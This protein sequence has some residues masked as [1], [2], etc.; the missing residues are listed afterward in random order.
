MSV[1][2]AATRTTPRWGLMAL[3]VL[4]ASALVF[5]VGFEQGT[6]TGG[7]PVLHEAFHD[8]RHLLGFPCH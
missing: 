5:L 6:L 7:L 4:A 1:I 2:T 8:A 3:A